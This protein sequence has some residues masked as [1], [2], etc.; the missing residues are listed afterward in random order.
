MN[1][2]QQDGSH[3]AK[4]ADALAHLKKYDQVLV[5]IVNHACDI[6]VDGAHHLDLEQEETEGDWQ[7]RWSKP[8]AH[9][10]ILHNGDQIA[11]TKY[12]STD[13]AVLVALLT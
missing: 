12:K 3:Q 1:L 4:N 7:L 2:Y 6:V 5:V 10:N 11:N 13:K 9:Y 8:G